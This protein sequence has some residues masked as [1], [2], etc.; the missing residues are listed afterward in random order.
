MTPAQ[1]AREIV[2]YHL[3]PGTG[4]LLEKDIAQALHEARKDAL[5]EAAAA[6]TSYQLPLAAFGEDRGPFYAAAVRA[7]KD[8][9]K[10]TTDN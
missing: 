5:E 6:V 2:A 10:P 8:T 3:K 1:R 7:L 9:D 4:H